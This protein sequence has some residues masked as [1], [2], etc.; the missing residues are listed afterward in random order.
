VVPP[1][2]HLPNSPERVLI[3]GANGH[4]GTRLI[5]RLAAADEPVPVRAVVRS[6]RAAATLREKTRGAAEPVV[7]DPRDVEALACAADG[8]SAAVHLVGILKEGANSRF[9][10]AHE[11]ISV[12]LAEASAR[13][14]LRRIVYL[15]ILGSHPG[16]P[17]A[18]LAS[19]GRAERILLESKTPALVL[20]VPMVI[21]EDDFASRAL[22]GQARAPF[23]LLPRGGRSLEQPIDANDVVSAILAGVRAPAAAGGPL[24]DVALDLAGPRSLPRREILALCAALYGR[25]PP[26][27][28]PVPLAIGRTAA[29]LFEKILADPPVSRA[30]LG[31][32]DHDDDIDPTDT[33]RR[34]GLE[35][36]PLD[37]T[38][39]RCVGPEARS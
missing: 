9:V 37:A 38:L 6:E 2:L 20:R 34:L 23:V 4:L 7:L 30:M 3:T 29:F 5:A 18:C 19:K 14:G 10:D 15:S 1:E 27:V 39:R 33:C 32:L 13:A 31:V 16:S 25:K 24:D 11:N 35:L 36:T 8:C 12:A 22:S 28:I 26:N 21:G 17:N